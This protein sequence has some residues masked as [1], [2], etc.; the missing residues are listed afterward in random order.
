MGERKSESRETRREG[1]PGSNR[2]RRR[3]EAEGSLIL[4]LQQECGW[5]SVYVRT[6]ACRPTRTRLSVLLGPVSFLWKFLSALVI[7]SCL[8]ACRSK[9]LGISLF[10]RVC[11]RARV[12]GIL[13]ALLLFFIWFFWVSFSPPSFFTYIFQL[14]GCA[15]GWVSAYYLPLVLDICAR[16]LSSPK[17][18]S[19]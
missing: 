19:G 17:E 4:Y 14:D 11:L 2:T 18:S 6:R 15:R 9:H 12:C 3:K 1:D 16:R 8:S 10:V 7:V 5:V 13:R